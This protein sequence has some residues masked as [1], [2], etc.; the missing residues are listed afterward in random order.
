MKNGP[1]PLGKRWEFLCVITVAVLLLLT[2][3]PAKDL[4]G[5]AKEVG[6]QDVEAVLE[7]GRDFNPPVEIT[8]V[9]TQAG[10]ISPGQR[11]TAGED[12]FKGLAVTVRNDSGEPI[13]H[14][15]LKLLFPRPKGQ[16]RELDFVEMLDY[17]E[18]PVPFADGRRPPPSSAKAVMP[19]E[20]VELRLADAAYDDLRALLRESRFPQKI[21]RV[22]VDVALLGFGDG[23]IWTAGKRYAFDS[24][25]PGELIPL[26]KKAQP[27]QAGQVREGRRPRPGGVV[28]W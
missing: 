4:H 8:S 27:R 13:T 17:G 28:V 7:K 5:H 9:K 1:P 19:G 16:E 3:S 23:T 26:K 15:S 22:R 24:D 14:I 6:Q 10:V 18:S 20:S 11:F 12:W 2:P 21:K 25:R